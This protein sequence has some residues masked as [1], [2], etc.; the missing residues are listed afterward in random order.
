MTTAR[1]CALRTS[2]IL[3]A[4]KCEC[5]LRE[6]QV[7]LG[8]KEV[9]YGVDIDA[10][11]RWHVEHLSSEIGVLE[12]ERNFHTV[13]CPIG[14]SIRTDANGESQFYSAVNILGDSQGRRRLKQDCKIVLGKYTQR[15]QKHIRKACFVRSQFWRTLKAAYT[16]SL[17]I[18]NDFIIF[19]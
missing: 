4:E 19:R 1:S 15:M 6:S 12:E 5:L 2:V 3:M 11:R 18:T 13:D 9:L 10:S 8:L 17:R 14:F 16:I 7:I